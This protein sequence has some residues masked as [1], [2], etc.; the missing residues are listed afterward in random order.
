MS[1]RMAVLQTVPPAPSNR[2]PQIVP[3]ALAGAAFALGAAAILGYAVGVD[4]LRRWGGGAVNPMAA[5]TLMLAALGALPIEEPGARRRQLAGTGLL[6]LVALLVLAD[7]AT[8]GILIDSGGGVFAERV[9]ADRAQG[10]RNAMSAATALC[11]LVLAG[12]QAARSHG[13]VLP[14]QVAA[15]AAAVPPI[16]A[17]AGAAYG[18][19]AL[20]GAMPPQVALA[21]LAL[22]AALLARDPRAGVAAVLVNE[23]TS[24]R[25]ARLVLPAALAIPFLCDWLFLAAQRGGIGSFETSLA[26]F[27]G[28]SVGASAGLLIYTLAQVDRIDR[29]RRRAEWR[30]SFEGDQDPLTGAL[31]RAAF[32]REIDAALSRPAGF[33]LLHAELDGY[34]ALKERF[35]AAAADDILRFAAQRL[36]G[37]LRPSDV[38]ARVGEGEF[39]VLAPGASACLAPRLSERV[40]AALMRPFALDGERIPVDAAVGAFTAEPGADTTSA[41]AVKMAEEAL[42]AARIQRAS[43]IEA[44]A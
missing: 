9:E 42:A 38:V 30:L 16:T 7:A 15:L 21:L 36:I 37:V 20:A 11:L 18:S 6:A 5:A 14:A 39:A 4:V 44:R 29:R 43:P 34:A 3:M 28:G 27:V 19:A 33:V 1:M 26:L 12:A 10:V 17:L 32:Y 8:G 22:T 2:R 41:L 31:G 13:L 23:R 25:V 40:R 35:G 24:G